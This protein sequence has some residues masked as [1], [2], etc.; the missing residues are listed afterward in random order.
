MIRTTV[1]LVLMA[2]LGGGALGLWVGAP[3]ARPVTSFTPSSLSGTPVLQQRPA[4][5]PLNVRSYPALGRRAIPRPFEAD[6]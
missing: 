3:A 1:P 5:S 6:V 2:M 4:L